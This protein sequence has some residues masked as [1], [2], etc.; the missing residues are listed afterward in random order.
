MLYQQHVEPVVVRGRDALLEGGVRLLR[1][2]LRGDEGKALRD[3]LD[4]RIDGHGRHPQGEEQHTGG[5]LRPHAG[6]SAQPRPRVLERHLA[7]ELQVP[8]GRTR[9]HG[10]KDR[11]DARPLLLGQAPVL[12]GRDQ[13][14]HGRRRHLVPGVITAQELYEGAPAVRVRRVLREHGED[15]FGDAVAAGSVHRRAVEGGQAGHDLGGRKGHV[16]RSMRRA[17][18]G[19]TGTRA[20]SRA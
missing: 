11:L 5:G 9:R 13:F 8:A 16:E 12:D 18:A 6:Q 3:A 1:R 17:T 10:V 14:A 20:H 19:S 7:Q 2:Q 15:E 4:V